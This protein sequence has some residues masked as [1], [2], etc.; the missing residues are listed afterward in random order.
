MVQCLVL[1]SPS[2]HNTSKLSI[3]SLFDQFPTQYPT[4]NHQI[5]TMSGTS[6]V[7]NSQV[8]EAGDQV[9]FRGQGIN[10]HQANHISEK[11]TQQRHRA[12]EGGGAIPRGKEEL[13]RRS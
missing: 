11:R 3:Q 12:A 10:K 7:G 1:S 8:Y 5:I 13:P 6:N 4:N 2:P 9:G